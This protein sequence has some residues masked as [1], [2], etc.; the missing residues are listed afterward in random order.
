MKCTAWSCFSRDER[1]RLYSSNERKFSTPAVLNS[2]LEPRCMSRIGA[3]FR[4]TIWPAWA[5]KVVDPAA[6]CWCTNRFFIEPSGV[7]LWA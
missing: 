4:L 3:P 6:R 1:S 7:T 2:W 5:L